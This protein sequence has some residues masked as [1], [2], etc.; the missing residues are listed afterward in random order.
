MIEIDGLSRQA[1]WPSAQ[2][3]E[4][5]QTGCACDQQVLMAVDPVASDEPGENGAVDTAWGAQID[6]FHTGA[7]AQR[8]RI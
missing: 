6:I 8:G 3:S 5:A 1:L 7:L 2:A 4:L